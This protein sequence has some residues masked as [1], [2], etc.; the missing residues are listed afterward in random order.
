MLTTHISESIVVETRVGGVAVD[1]VLKMWSPDG[2]TIPEEEAELGGGQKRRD[3]IT[4]N[5]HRR[6]NEEEE[7]NG[8]T[9]AEVDTQ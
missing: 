7:G 8:N 2:E 1:C 5:T 9:Q 3:T 4:M 6:W